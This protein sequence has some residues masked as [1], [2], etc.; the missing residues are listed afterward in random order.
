[1]KIKEIAP[2]TF[3]VDFTTRE[4]L[5]RAFVRFQE[6]YESPAFKEKIFTLDEYET[7]YKSYYKKDTFSYYEDWSGC[8]VPSFVFDKFRQ[9]VMNPLSE[10][11]IDLLSVLPND[12]KKYY[13]IGTFDGGKEDVLFHEMC[14]SLFYSSSLYRKEVLILLDKYDKDLYEVKNYILEM[15]YHESVLLD[16]VQAYVLGSKSDLDED[17]ISYPPELHNQ[18]KEIFDK[19]QS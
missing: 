9:G 4:E 19:Y 8:N 18:L 16:E 6:Y 3:H 1:M 14:H 17:T 10:R 15:G 11:E 2:R 5:L 13:V 12:G 7:W